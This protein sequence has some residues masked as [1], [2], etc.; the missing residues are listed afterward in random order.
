MPS[1]RVLRTLPLVLVAGLVASC[2]GS[3]STTAGTG[4]V[5][6]DE[7]GDGPEQSSAVGDG[8]S[9]RLTAELSGAAEVP[10]HG[11]P[12]GSGS[13]TVVVEPGRS[14]L[15]YRIEVEGLEEVDGTSVHEGG[16]GENG[17]V[18]LGLDPPLG[19]SSEGCVTAEPALLE[20]VERTPE[21]FY[22]NIRS[23]DHPDGA[24]RGQLTAQ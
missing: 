16:A 15:C 6:L 10:D 14:Q 18:L 8:A 2:G 1:P 20:Q 12:D 13:A 11:D 7:A 22:L 5:A 23:A 24:V 9:T 19:G 4:P 3:G 17:A 21:G